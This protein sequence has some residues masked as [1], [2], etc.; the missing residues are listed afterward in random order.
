MLACNDKA[1]TQ[2]YEYLIIYEKAVV[3]I[4]RLNLNRS[5]NKASFLCNVQK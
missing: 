4:E 5:K 2:F 1:E 3:F